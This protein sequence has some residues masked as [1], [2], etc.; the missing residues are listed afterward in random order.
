ML[1]KLNGKMNK[2]FLKKFRFARIFGKSAKFNGQ[3][4]GLDHTLEDEDTVELHMK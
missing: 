1:L 3:S 4:V 2:D